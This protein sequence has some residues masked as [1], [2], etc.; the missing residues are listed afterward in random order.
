[1]FKPITSKKTRG[2]FKK[3]FMSFTRF[4]KEKKK[5]KLTRIN[6]RDTKTE[7]L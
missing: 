3:N 6:G 4:A 7:R 2:L 5:L 1:M